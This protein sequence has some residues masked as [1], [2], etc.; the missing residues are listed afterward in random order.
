MGGG[1]ARPPQNGGGGGRRGDG[2]CLG[3]EGR[4]GRPGPV[5]GQR[6]RGGEPQAGKEEEGGLAPTP[7]LYPNQRPSLPQSQSRTLVN[8]NCILQ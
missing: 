7:Q 8:Y 6:G 3:P 1:E 2:L 4:S 5:G